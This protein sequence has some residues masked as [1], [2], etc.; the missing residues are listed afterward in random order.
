MKR[1]TLVLVLASAA[2]AAIAQAFGPPP[3]APMRGDF[4]LTAG[5]GAAGAP[6]YLGSDE[7]RARAL[8]IVQARWASGA[9]AGLGGIGWRW[10][11]AEGLSA[12][13]RLGAEFGRR[14][15]AS[16]ALRGMGNIDPSAELG[17]AVSWRLLGP[18]ALTAG[19]RAGSGDERSGL[20]ADIGLRGA[21]P[22]A[23]GHRLVL[24]ASA[25]HANGPATRSLFGVTAAQAAT[26]GYAV[27]TPQG[28]WRDVAF[29]VGWAWQ[30]NPETSLLL[31][32]SAQ[33]LLG[34][35][36]QSQLTRERN[37]AGVNAALL[38]RW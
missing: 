2:R 14:E 36:A 16:D 33:R 11:L 19:V 12:S 24:G 26:S 3:D 22:L 15:S 17:L 4:E 32:A 20:L 38:W 35:A 30:L 29:N 5:L 10:Q 23:P 6:A 28:G 18:L 34:D 37:G 27:S 8:P 25:T 1:A 31:G 21:V 9:F 13:V 7:H